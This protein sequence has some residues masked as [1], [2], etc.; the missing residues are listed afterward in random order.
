MIL[1]NQHQVQQRVP[2]ISQYQNNNTYQT[3]LL[4]H[5][6]N[7]NLEKKNSASTSST[8]QHIDLPTLHNKVESLLERANRV[9]RE[10]NHFMAKSFG[11]HNMSLNGR[12]N[13]TTSDNYSRMDG[14]PSSSLIGSESLK[15]DHIKN[16]KN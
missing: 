2:F 11:P 16:G 13:H 10:E 14:R 1:A 6:N 12:S 9:N 8:L 4:S 7:L 5:T 3:N 15:E